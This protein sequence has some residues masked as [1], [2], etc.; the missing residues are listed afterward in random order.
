MPSNFWKDL[1]SPFFVLAPMEDVTD[2]V[3]R[4]VVLGI[5]DPNILK[6]VFTEFTSTDGLMDERG[7]DRVSERLIV[8][9]T[10]KKLL[11]SNEIKLVAQIWGNDPEKFR[12]SAEI[13][14]KM[15]LFDGIDINMGCPVKKVVKKNTCSALIRKPDLASEII[16]ATKSGTNLPVSVKTRIGF[17]TVVTEEWISVLLK[18]HPA[19]ITLHGRTQKMQS[20]GLADWNEVRKAVDIRNQINPDVIIIGN[21]DV[22]TYADGIKKREFS[23]AEGIM[24]GRGIFHNPWLF[25][26]VTTGILPEEKLEL[27]SKHISLYRQTW[28]GKKSINQLKRFFK[29]YI[30]GFDGAAALRAQLMETKN[31]TGLE[32]ILSPIV[33]PV[34]TL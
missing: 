33:K 30:N 27:I 8:N 4:E 31:Y 28:E 34:N 11:I 16:E 23:G 9:G 6:V 10:E 17:N 29:I 14:S 7:F 21:G 5:S 32:E 12:N 19:A 24:V 18:A 15:G 1:K 22:L 3:F 2:T 26:Q 20:E 25:N 13:I